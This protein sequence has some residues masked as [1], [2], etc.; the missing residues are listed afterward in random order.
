MERIQ[1][2]I[3]SVLESG[4]K[5]SENWLKYYYVRVYIFQVQE[6]FVHL[7]SSFYEIIQSKIGFPMKPISLSPEEEH[8]FY[9]LREYVEKKNTYVIFSHSLIVV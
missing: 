3:Y 8:S 7:F 9:N 2:L 5:L 4:K 1:K 6:G